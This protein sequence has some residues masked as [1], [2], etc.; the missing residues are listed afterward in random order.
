MGNR[1]ADPRQ[2]VR[3]PSAAQDCEVHTC[4]M[5]R[6]VWGDRIDGVAGTEGACG[7]LL[8]GFEC[9][10]EVVSITQTE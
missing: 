6:D 1:T 4:R 2:P 9:G 5:V 8:C 7:I 10:L 3:G